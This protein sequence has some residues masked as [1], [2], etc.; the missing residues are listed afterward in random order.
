MTKQ[1]FL[2]EPPPSEQL[3]DYDRAHLKT[4]IRLLDAE[5]DGAD[6]EEVVRVIFGLDPAGEPERAE[7]I[8][9]SHLS[10]ARWMTESGYRKLLRASYH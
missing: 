4:Y 1:A 8:H 7:R 3:T 6:W 5:A 9:K 10:R 2:D